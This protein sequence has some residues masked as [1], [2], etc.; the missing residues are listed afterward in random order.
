MHRDPVGLCHQTHF[1]PDLYPMI[2][3]FRNMALAALLLLGVS[4]TQAQQKKKSLPAGG[5]APAHGLVA[6][7]HASLGGVRSNSLPAS[8]MKQLLDSTL[9]ARDSLGHVYPVVSFDFGYGTHN[10]FYND[11]TG[12]PASY[13]AYSSFH[14]KGN[15][16]DSVWRHGIRDQI[17]SG[18]G[19]FFDHIIAKGEKGVFYLSTPL[20]FRIN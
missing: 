11:S 9:I 10:T 1:F 3:M 20:H 13:P 12:R 4:A 6:V 7:Y 18:D 2:R 16:L 5:A 17:R 15:R 14:F 19:L 8:M